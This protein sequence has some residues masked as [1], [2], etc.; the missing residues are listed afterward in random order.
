MFWTTRLGPNNVGGVNP[1]AGRAVYQATNVRVLDFHQIPNALFGG[2]DPPVPGTVSFEVQW[3]DVDDRLNLK[4]PAN[5]FAGEYV[6]GK[7]RMAWT[8]TVGDLQYV[9]DPIETSS[10]KFAQLG[11][12]RNG[13]FYP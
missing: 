10:S 11:H 6:R 7:A 12:E 4:N 9:S 3:F 13:S 8:A 1:G 2:G 5:G